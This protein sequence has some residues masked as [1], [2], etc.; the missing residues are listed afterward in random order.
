MKNKYIAEIACKILAIYIFIRGLLQLTYI[1]VSLITPIENNLNILVAS[2]IPVT[3][4]FAASA[5]LWI[6]AKALAEYIAPADDTTQKM[7]C[8]NPGISC[9]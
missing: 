8:G 7:P 1:P 2:L 4:L 6:Y 3:I 9:E 5:L